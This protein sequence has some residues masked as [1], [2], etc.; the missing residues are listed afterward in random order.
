LAEG[1]TDKALRVQTSCRL[2]LLEPKL[3]SHTDA[4]R[5]E[6]WHWGGR[7]LVSLYYARMRKETARPDGPETGFDVWQEVPVTDR[8]DRVQPFKFGPHGRRAPSSAISRAAQSDG[9]AAGRM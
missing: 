3:P 7:R 8:L 9:L 1:P 5:L 4:N 6:G 2:R